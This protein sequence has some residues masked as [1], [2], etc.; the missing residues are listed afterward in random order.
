MKKLILFVLMICG[1]LAAHADFT[2]PDFAFPQTVIEDAEAHLKTS[3]GLQKMEAVMEITVAK[4]AINPDSLKC[5]PAFISSAANNENN[6]EAKGLMTLYEAYIL[7]K[8]YSYNSWSYDKVDA[9]L[10]PFPQDV[11]TWSGEQFK[12]KIKLLAD[13]ALTILEPYYKR[14]LKDFSEVIECTDVNSDFYPYLRDFLYTCIGKLSISDKKYLNSITDLC[15]P[16][17]PEWAVWV[18]SDIYKYEQLIDLYKKYPAG[19]CG[20]YLLRKAM[21]TQVYSTL[22]DDYDSLVKLYQE[23]FNTHAENVLTADLKVQYEILTKPTALMELANYY[24]AG[25]MLKIPCK[26]A[27]T[28]QIGFKILRFSPQTSNRASESVFVKDVI[29]KVEKTLAVGVDTLFVS[30]DTPGRYYFEAVCDGLQSRQGSIVTFTP[31][32]PAIF[33]SGDKQL[34][35]VTDF[36]SGEPARNITVEQR[37]N[38]Q[39]T[40]IGKTDSNGLLYFDVTGTNRS[41]G[42]IQLRDKV[43]KVYFGSYL[44]YSR[45]YTPGNDDRINGSIFVERPVFHPGDSVNWSL[46]AVSHNDRAGTS[47]LLKDKEIDVVFYNANYSPVD[48]LHVTTNKYGQANGSF[49][50]PKGLLTGRF[51]I[52][53]CVD[54]FSIS[55]PVTVSDFKAPVFELKEVQVALTDTVYI[56]EGSAIRY[57]GAAVPAAKVDVA[58][59]KAL[60]YNL[61]HPV[62][63]ETEKTF[64]GTTAADG[65]FKVAIPRDS[66]GDGNYRCQIIVTSV[67]ADIA[68]SSVSF[69]AGKPYMVTGTT[70]NAIINVDSP[71]KLNIYAFDSNLKFATLDAK[72]QLKKRTGEYA[73]GGDCRID[74]LGTYIDF[75][76]VAPGSYSL[77][78]CPVD[79]TMFDTLDAGYIS[80]YSIAQNIVPE[81][82]P[83]LVTEK[84][85]NIGTNDKKFAVKVGVPVESYVYFV[86]NNPSNGKIGATLKKLDAGF[87]DVKLDIAA[88]AESITYEIF[89]VKDG[90]SHRA[91][92]LTVNRTKPS[93]A[94]TLKGE[95]MRDRLVPGAPETW[96]LKLSAIDG[97][98]CPGV[99]VATMYNH[100][101]DALA[102]LSW[103]D[104]VGQLLSTTK[105]SERLVSNFLQNYVSTLQVNGQ[106]RRKVYFT[107]LTPSFLFSDNMYGNR[108]YIRGANKMMATAAGAMV[109]ESVAYD[110][111]APVMADLAANVE[112]ASDGA[113]SDDSSNE[114][115]N[116]RAAETLQAFWMPAITVD[117]NGDAV[118]NFTVPDAIGAWS[119]RASAWTED[120]RAAS[121]L[122]TL[123][124]SKP[125]MVQ[126]TLP[127]F[128]RRGDKLNILATV[129]NN[130]D[131]TATVTTVVEVFDPSTGKA[132]N[133]VS[134]ASTIPAKGQTTVGCDVEAPI[135]LS[136]LGYR[137]K[138]SDGNFT[139]GEQTSIPILDATTTAIDSELFY[140][141]DSYTEFTT[142]LPADLSGN[143]IVAVQY[144][145]NP[146]WD[147]VRTLPG[148]YESEP[149]TATSAA[150][151]IYSALVAKGLFNRYPEI[152]TA[153]D[154]WLANPSDSAFVSK[155]YKNEDLKLALLA[156]TPFVG[157]ANAMS[158]QMN[159]LAVTFDET[160]INSVLAASIHKLATLQRADGGFAW[161]DW[162]D[163]SSPWITRC[164]LTT[165]GRLERLGFIM[166]N[167]SLMSIIDKAF[168][169]IDSNVES[170]DYGYT[171]LYS[172]YPERKPSTLKGQQ[173]IDK[174]KQQI[175]ANWKKSSTA[176]KAT[177]ALI[178]DALGNKSVANLIMASVKQFAEKNTKRGISFGS[179]LSVDSYA[180]L[181]EAF[182]RITPDNVSII[183]GMRQWL[184]LQTQANDDLFA[185]DPTTLV[186]A[187]LSTGTNWT[188]I[189]T[190]STAAVSVDGVPLSLNKIE[191]ITGTFSQRL[192]S[193]GEKRVLSV[194][195][196]EG[197]P[198]SYGSV[199]SV[200]TR[201]MTSVKAHECDGISISKRFLIENNGKWEETDNF[202]LGQRVRVQLLVRASRNME[203]ITIID[204][205]PSA[206]EP[207]D[208]IPGWIYNGASPAAY[209][210]N[211]DTNTRLFITYL[212][213]GTYYYT[214]DMTAT[215]S[216][217]FTSG[218]ATLQ[219]QYA[220]ELTARSGAAIVT[221]GK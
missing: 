57:S 177:D 72:W 159:R 194:V 214:Y 181:L 17:T 174:V 221:V 104:N 160:T 79:T 70:D 107:L 97:S 140:L 46:V 31:W 210:E 109:E 126:P 155:L 99:M 34:L 190:G 50:I 69:R 52:E 130:T 179:V 56:L 45:G 59:S 29:H 142:T 203:Y 32:L 91:S 148:L 173:C 122:A 163:E 18:S 64:T 54:R 176:S 187:I 48:T 80:L 120:C 102:S 66:L 111:A 168:A 35:V 137:V 156:Q 123:T 61:W 85:I 87:T 1:A 30:V 206:F 62:W 204:D 212:P 23:Y 216:G 112:S 124:A 86:T 199:V 202:S 100:A 40:T 180:Q 152:R 182:S 101:L 105:F 129:M 116:F 9:P 195:R 158:D 93:Q 90:K 171:Y 118:L 201:P 74:S 39:F 145:Q 133:T 95:S 117:E 89:T 132:L 77:D 192:P 146:V 131:S 141:T 84:N 110:S 33:S 193:S 106:V 2:T 37:N 67:S 76:N 51:S 125:I 220:P 8:I 157:A 96:K 154:I 208:Q 150:S 165:I 197:S 139:D 149:K 11:A 108:I 14:P 68:E 196:P 167:K 38:N 98:P 21:E 136:E 127:R 58:V 186:A 134:H 207:V 178:L 44:N 16:G 114:E 15:E 41:S 49:F 7:D 63:N 22:S 113:H 75:V 138:A 10:L 60:Y 213:K 47:A 183:N 36:T 53:A 20:S 198:I 71:A 172:M 94:L 82:I 143:G 6:V 166:D 218:A 161:G 73:A 170:P 3:S 200:S 205:R 215:Y 164:V 25:A 81:N 144:C 88:D 162:S 188:S 83:I 115:F 189:P 184:I 175:I 103:P 28:S 153:L 169:Y 4:S 135:G 19:L 147:V 211:T 26:Y 78:I 13:S 27:N 219:S 217:S 43:N 151:S 209:R 185:W 5:M 55:A 65:S 92:T 119:F 191:A 121:M 12:Y 24:Q 42:N 128:M